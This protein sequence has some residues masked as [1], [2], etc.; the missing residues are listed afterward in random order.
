MFKHILVPLDGSKLAEAVFERLIPLAV[1]LKSEITLIHIIEKNAPQAVHGEKHLSQID[2]AAKYLKDTA[3]RY[4]P[5][6]LTYK[7][8]VHET[9]VSDVARSIVEHSDELAPD[10]IF[11]AA[12]GGGG[13]RDIM[14]GSIAQQ[15][16]GMGELPVVLIRPQEKQAHSAGLFQNILVGLDGNPEHENGLTLVKEL[17]PMINANVH[18]LTVVNT[19][20]T[21]GGKEAATGMLLPSTTRVMLDMAEDHAAG[22]LSGKAEELEKLGVNVSCLVK[23]GEPVV[24]IVEAAKEVRSDLI[25]FGTHGRCGLEAFWAGSV[26]PKMPSLTSIPLLFVPFCESGDCRDG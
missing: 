25:V 20:E 16:I 2:E 3:A 13:L 4:L 15:V 6:G 22:R 14:V 11:L 19:L 21:L 8:H 24:K 10:L 7:T 23:R 1:A 12:H 17:A 9:E 18:L 5:E 26:A